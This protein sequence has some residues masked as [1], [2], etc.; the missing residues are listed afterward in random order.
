[1]VEWRGRWRVRGWVM[2]AH[3]GPSAL[4]KHVWNSP[5][6]PRRGSTEAPQGGESR[7][8]VWVL[9]NSCCWDWKR[10]SIWETWNRAYRKLAQGLDGFDFSV[11]KMLGIEEEIK[12][13]WWTVCL[14]V[15][16][17][18]VSTG[19]EAGS[20]GETASSDV[21]LRSIFLWG[22]SCGSD[23]RHICGLMHLRVVFQ[24]AQRIHFDLSMELIAGRRRRWKRPSYLKC[25][26]VVKLLQKH[27]TLQETYEFRQWHLLPK[28]KTVSEK[29][30]FRAQKHCIFVSASYFDK[31]KLLSVTIQSWVALQ[32]PKCLVWITIWTCH[33][34]M[35]DLQPC[36]G[37]VSQAGF[38][39]LWCSLPLRINIGLRLCN[40]YLLNHFCLFASQSNHNL[41]ILLPEA[42][43]T[44]MISQLQLQ[45][46]KIISSQNRGARRFWEVMVNE[47]TKYFLKS[48]SHY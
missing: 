16:L 21:V 18:R 34:L 14:G 26:W 27:I 7:G 12:S 33:L 25:P 10:G 35:A 4:L 30:E 24:S 15:S 41:E 17:L 6:G 28:D 2:S 31:R 44:N 29:E 42:L 43:Q 11:E 39:G 37:S 36:F 20:W 9:G 8:Q 19:E 40:I 48:R 38:A 1:M 13:A 5:A 23:H 45:M 22:C 47:K 46:R 3:R 32:V